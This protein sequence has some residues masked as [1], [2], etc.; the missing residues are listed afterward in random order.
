M[1]KC[2]SCHVK[3]NSDEFLSKG[4]ILKTCQKCLTQRSKKNTKNNRSF[5]TSSS[6]TPSSDTRYHI[7]HASLINSTEE[8]INSVLTESANI[9]EDHLIALTEAEF[10]HFLQNQFECLTEDTT[11][12]RE[13]VE[14]SCRINLETDGFL[15]PKEVATKFRI[16][17]ER[18]DGYKWK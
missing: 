15:N 3:K 5:E 11:V 12:D 7:Q 16:D 14:I 9:N 1:L 18:E 17:V 2:S 4:R 6:N 13:C 8:P 10:P